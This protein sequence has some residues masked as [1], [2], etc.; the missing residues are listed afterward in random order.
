[1]VVTDERAVTVAVIYSCNDSSISEYNLCVTAKCT[2]FIL[3]E[4]TFKVYP[5][6]NARAH[7]LL[8]VNAAWSMYHTHFYDFIQLC[9]ILML[10]IS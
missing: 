8:I 2:V 6:K 9:I 10:S 5:R 1:M 3:Y 7:R 4:I